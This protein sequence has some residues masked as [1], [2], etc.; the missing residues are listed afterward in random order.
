MCTRKA[1]RKRGRV[2]LSEKTVVKKERDGLNKRE[3]EIARRGRYE[4]KE[5]W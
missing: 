3:N 2:R 5:R 4:V 1:M